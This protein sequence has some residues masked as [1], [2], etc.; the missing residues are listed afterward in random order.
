MNGLIQCAIVA[1]PQSN[2]SK[3]CKW[4]GKQCR[5]WCSRSS[6]IWVYTVCPGIS[7]RKLRIIMV[8]SYLHIS[9]KIIGNFGPLI[10]QWAVVIRTEAAVE[11]DPV[12]RQ[13]K[14]N[15][16][17]CI[18]YR[19]IIIFITWKKFTRLLTILTIQQAYITNGTES[20]FILL[21]NHWAKLCDTNCRCFMTSSF[22]SSMFPWH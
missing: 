12:L 18:S 14:D 10:L 15:V 3:R 22:P 5:P 11:C 1:L 9:R 8:K 16:R 7:V 17:A 6:L 4:N 20:C 21:T 19:R 13:I 2:E